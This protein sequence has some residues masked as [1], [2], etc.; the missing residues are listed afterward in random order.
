MTPKKI[1]SFRYRLVNLLRRELAGVQ[2]DSIQFG[3]LA[4]RLEKFMMHESFHLTEVQHSA[5][6]ACWDCIGALHLEVY[7]H[8]CEMRVA[9]EMAE[10]HD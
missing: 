8:Q 10:D 9:R 3:Q 2:I 5:E 1:R 7:R 6:C 4:N